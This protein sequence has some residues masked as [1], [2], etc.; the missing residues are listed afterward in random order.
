MR[1]TTSYK[2]AFLLLAFV[3]LPFSAMAQEIEYNWTNGSTSGNSW[4]D[5]ENWGID[6]GSGLIEVGDDSSITLNTG[7]KVSGGTVRNNGTSIFRLR[8]TL[9]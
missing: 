1:R 5:P 3:A 7:S 2:F 9:L 8:E 4:F 6:D